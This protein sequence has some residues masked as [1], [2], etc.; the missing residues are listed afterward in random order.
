[1]PGFLDSIRQE[2]DRGLVQIGAR[3]KQLLETTQVRSQ[4]R[5]LQTR[6]DQGIQELGQVVYEMLRRGPLDQSRLDPYITVLQ[7]IDAQIVSLEEQL[8]RAH[9]AAQMALM[10]TRAPAFAYCTCGG[11]LKETSRFCPRC[12]KDVTAIVQRATTQVQVGQ[13][14]CPSCG[15][16]VGPAVR[17]CP[18]CGQSLA[19]GG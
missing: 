1:M 2:I 16:A 4:I 3:S 17:F 5:L 19:Q 8:Q 12:G 9:E 10:A 18:S 13:R 11:P 7:Q 6:R 14:A 15:T